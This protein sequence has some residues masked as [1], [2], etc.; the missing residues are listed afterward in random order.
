MF[1]FLKLSS[2][3]SIVDVFVRE[4]FKGELLFGKR[5]TMNLKKKGT[6]CFFFFFFVSGAFAHRLI[7]YF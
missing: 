3:L 1:F 7:Y 4:K 5:G 6:S 2:R